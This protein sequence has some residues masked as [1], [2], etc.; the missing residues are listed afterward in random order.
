MNFVMN[1]GPGAGLLAWTVNQQSI[2]LPGTT[3][4]DSHNID[5]N[6]DV[7]TYDTYDDDNNMINTIVIVM[8]TITIKITITIIKLQTL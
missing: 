5:S 2:A 7:N 3:D 8:M 4:N 1:Q 6:D